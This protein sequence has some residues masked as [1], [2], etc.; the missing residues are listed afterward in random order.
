MVTENYAYTHHTSKKKYKGRRKKEGR[1][2]R[3]KEIREEGKKQNTKEGEQIIAQLT[4]GN[5]CFF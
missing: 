4:Q 1:E 2:G 5:P 3:K